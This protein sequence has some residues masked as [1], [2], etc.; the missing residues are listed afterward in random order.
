MAHSGDLQSVW[1]TDDHPDHVLD[2]DRNAGIS[3]IHAAVASGS[4]KMV[5]RRV[6]EEN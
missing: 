2:S 5:D 1:P 4:S 6:L 3:D